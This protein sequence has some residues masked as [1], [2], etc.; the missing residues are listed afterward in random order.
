MRRRRTRSKLHELI[1]ETVKTVNLSCRSAPTPL[2][3]GVN[4][5]RAAFIDQSL[6]GRL[7]G[8]LLVAILIM[9]ATWL[10]A[11]TI[12]VNP[13]EDAYIRQFDPDRTFGD[14]GGE[15]SLVSGALGSRAQFEVRRALLRFDVSAIPPGSVVNSATLQMTVVMVPLSPVNST[16]DIRRVLQSWTEGGVSWNSRSGAGT[17]WQVPGATGAGDSV[18]T[19]SSFVAVGSANFTAYTFPSTAAL[20][21]DVQGWVNDASSNFG[22][23]L[24]SENEVSPET[25]RR[26]GAREDSL[27]APVLTIN[28]SLPSLGV[29]IQPPSQTVLAGSTV[30]FTA[31]ATGTPPFSY[32]WYFGGNP[33]VG[34]TSS[35]L[36]LNNVQPS[37]SGPYTVTVS[38]QTGTVTSSPATLAVIA[39]QGPSVTI[40]SPTNG[41][42]FPPHSDVVL[43][44][45]VTESNGTISYVEFLLG[46]NVVGVVSNSPYTMIL[47]NLS[48]GSYT[49]TAQATDTQ[50]N[51]GVSVSVNFSTGVPVVNITSPTNGAKFPE[52][53]DVLL[54]ARASE[55]GATI[56]NIAF[57]LNT[58]FVGQAPSDSL[59]SI[60]SNLSAGGY[61]FM[62][63]ATDNQSNVVS[64]SVNFSVI[65]PPGIALTAPASNSSFVL[66][67][68][69]VITAVVRSKGANI[70]R[71]DFLAARTLADG[72]VGIINI[73]TASTN[74]SAPQT[75]VWVPA[76]VGDYTLFARALDELGQ[77]GESSRVPVRVFTPELILPTITITNAPANFSRQTEPPVV[78]EGTARDNIGVDQIKFQVLN[79]TFLQNSSAPQTAEGTTNWSASVPLVP[80]KNAIRIWSQDLATNKS[81]VVTRFYTYT[82][83][84]P[85]TVILN[86]D[87][88]VAPNLG[89]GRSLELGKVYTMTARPASEQ[90]FVRWEIRTN[91]DLTITNGVTFSTNATLN[92][93]MKSNLVLVADFEANPFPEGGGYTGL[94]FTAGTN[95]FRPENAG[96]F[97]LRLAHSGSFSGRIVLQG[98]THPFRGQFD[99]LG[100][101]RVAI[102]RRAKPPV[103]L[104]LQLDMLG[105]GTNITG[106]VRT[107]SDANTLTSDLEARRNGE[108]AAFAGQ[109]GFSLV[110]EVGDTVV[111]A[112]AAAS[113]SGNVSIR[114]VLQ[115]SRSFTFAT[116]ISSDGSVPFYVSFNRGDEVIAGWLQFGES[117]SSV[118]GQVFWVSPSFAG[119]SL[120]NAVTQ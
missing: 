73:G 7:I 101:G 72:N 24:I 93:E 52:H 48:A 58:N 22:W 60:A 113:S 85:L 82:V 112:A 15:P 28:Y 49:L 53:A 89:D 36:V 5:R 88:S 14:Y 109:R 41:A 70:S 77:I 12:T 74:L 114:G 47:S 94:F 61:Q 50:G 103:A 98:A 45:D 78:I 43:A 71:V 29:T 87:G 120:L 96:F 118:S 9:V 97:A 84:L 34:A 66:G 63:E 107:A 102:V 33:I 46:T 37:Q 30:T 11:A 110:D 35:T 75:I 21:A 42:V 105:G 57:F 56:T 51:A 91:E 19:P 76:E 99:A 38:D 18:S 64:S 31:N 106:T 108:A 69:I 86:G 67:S 8:V 25:A 6:R 1:G 90:I 55:T 4:E 80:G 100:K 115:P 92:F 111:N 54:A 2:K 16:F 20:V 17:P 3:R 10:R 81:A 117:D 23:M 104:S 95:F 119:V 39:V 59:S 62:A 32:Q 116:S 68:N 26:F 79:G 40:T 83:Q 44:A 65:P 13:K 27:H